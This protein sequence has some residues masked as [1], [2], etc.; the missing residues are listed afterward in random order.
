MTAAK[1]AQMDINAPMSASHE[2]TGSPTCISIA[3][4]MT[5]AKAPTPNRAEIKFE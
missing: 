4:A 2:Y 5:K 1:V 3:M